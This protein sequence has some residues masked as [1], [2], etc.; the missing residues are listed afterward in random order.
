MFFVL[1]SSSLVLGMG[2]PAPARLSSAWYSSPASPT[3]N[4]LRAEPPRTKDQGPGTKRDHTP[5]RERGKRSSLRIDP[6][7]GWAASFPAGLPMH[8]I[9]AVDVDRLAGAVSA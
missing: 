6:G 8:H 2:C 4:G 3:P 1:G 5:I 9:A 7:P